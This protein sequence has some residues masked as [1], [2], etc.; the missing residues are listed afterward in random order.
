[1]T[2]SASGEIKL[3]NFVY[4]LG[5]ALGLMVILVLFLFCKLSHQKGEKCY[6]N[7]HRL[8]NSTA[9]HWLQELV[10]FK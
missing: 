8:P 7:E 9:D 3:I 10:K 6:L 1:M 2:C 4:F 5:I